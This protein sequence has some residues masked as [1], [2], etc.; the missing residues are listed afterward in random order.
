MAIAQ[1][2]SISIARRPVSRVKEEGD[3]L[4]GEE[5]ENKEN[6]SLLVDA[7]EKGKAAAIATR[8]A[9]STDT[10]TG[11]ANIASEAAEASGTDY[12]SKANAFKFT[13]APKQKFAPQQVK[14][15]FRSL[16]TN[17]R[18]GGAVTGRGRGGGRGA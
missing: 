5:T 2:K 4:V 16:V 9:S 14:H 10:S 6:F 17:S 18:R 1:T 13:P 15:S 12:S 3:V 8:I 11:N 7:A